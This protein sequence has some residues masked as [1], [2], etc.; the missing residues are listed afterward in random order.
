MH[1][2]LVYLEQYYFSAFR[3][4]VYMSNVFVMVLQ[5]FHLFVFSLACFCSQHFSSCCYWDA[6]HMPAL[7][8]E[9]QLL[10]YTEIKQ[11]VVIIKIFHELI[12]D[13]WS[14]ASDLLNWKF[15][16]HASVE[17]IVCL[18]FY[19]ASQKNI[20]WTFSAFYY[21]TSAQLL[22]EWVRDLQLLSD[23]LYLFFLLT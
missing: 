3:K 18:L 5:H 15:W 7:K 20:F 4:C 21:S 6:H 2:L 19:V 22:I 23:C 12:N 8:T 1:F 17:W 11:C 9:L 16:L 14:V 13:Y 10:L